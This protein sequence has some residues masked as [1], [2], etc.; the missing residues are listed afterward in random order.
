MNPIVFKRKLRLL[1][2]K[3]R[4]IWSGKVTGP[5]PT[6]TVTSLGE[7]LEIKYGLAK[8][9]AAQEEEAFYKSTI[10]Y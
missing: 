3:A 8:D 9:K 6:A 2:A 7:Y 10:C 4:G 1:R 5:S